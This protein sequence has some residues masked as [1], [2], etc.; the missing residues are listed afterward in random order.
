MDPEEYSRLADR[1]LRR[2]IRHQLFPYSPFYRRVLDE[3]G[4]TAHG[5]GGASDL[6]QMPLITREQFA[7]TSGDFILRAPE[8]SIQR[9][10]PARQVSQVVVNKLLRG[11]AGADRELAD[12]YQTVHTL[13]TTGTTGEPLQI[14]LTRRD[15]AALSTQASRSLQVAGVGGGDFVLSLLEPSSA[16]GFWP[17]WL[18]AIAL[19]AE[20]LA[21][22]FLDPEFAAALAL[23]S[24]ATVIVGRAEDTLMVMEASGGIDTLRTLILGPERVSPVLRRRIQEEAGDQ[25]SVVATY[26]F[27]EARGFWAECMQGSL[28]PDSG[29]HLTGLEIVEVI[30]R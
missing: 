9:R 16:G 27:S 24:G 22:G 17:I 6:R 7:Q 28:H 23:K 26:G 8:T 14:H 2:Q 3:T 30:S 20:I 29:F 19:G 13:E 10:G 15:L 4:I 25:V 12:E 21:P 1:G 18:G 5:F 11:V